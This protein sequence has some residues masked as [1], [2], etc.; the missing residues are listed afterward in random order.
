MKLCRS[1]EFARLG[2]MR[3]NSP[4]VLD[5]STK[6]ESYCKVLLEPYLTR[7]YLFYHTLRRSAPRLP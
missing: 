5:L 7:N 2:R 3:E 4:A 1:R 6:S